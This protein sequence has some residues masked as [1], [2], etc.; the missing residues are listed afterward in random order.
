MRLTTVGT[1]TVSPHPMRVCSAQLVEAGAV[2]MLLDC[3]S[4][5]VHRLATLGIDW[6][7][8][9]HVALTHFHADHIADL[10]MLMMAWRWGQLP[11]R[12][13]PLT[14]YGPTGTGAVIE[15]MAA[16]YGDWMLAPGFPFTVR[17]LEADEVVRLGDDVRM[18]H[19]PVPHTDESVAY[20]IEENGCRLVY[21]GDTSPDEAM[22][23]WAADCDLLLT[24]CSLPDALAVT[25]HLTP[26]QAGELAV[27]ARARHLVLT[28]FYPPV[29]AADIATE[30]AAH[31]S[32]P[33]VLATDGW[34]IE[35]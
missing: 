9:T 27:A 20:C 30:V 13:A 29:E 34:S 12:G 32:G 11:P 33:L 21:T 5:V 19:H 3:G 10:P 18:T 16:L 31:Y 6:Q 35:L 2:R 4:G 17:E 26:R 14:L 24:E 7:S 8:I 28:H 23:R 25:G 1:G 22:G 15:K